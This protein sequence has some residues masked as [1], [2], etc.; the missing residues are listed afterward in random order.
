M[1]DSW[2]FTSLGRVAHV[3]MGQSPPSEYVSE[4]EGLGLPFLQGNAEFTDVHPKPGLWCRKPAKSALSG[5]ALISVRAPVGAINRADQDYCIGRGL[6][7]IRFSSV[8]PDFGYQA[9]ALYAAELRMVAQGTTFEAVGG[10]E[11]RE[12]RFPLAPALEQRRIAEILHTL[13]EA[14]RKTEEVIAKLQQMKQGLLHDLLTRGIDEN[15]ELRD[16]ERHPE[17]F[18]DSRL[19]RIPREWMTQRTSEVC[20]LGRGRVISQSYLLANPG[21]YPVYSSQSKDE[22][23]FG[24]IDTFDFEG[25]HVTWTTDGAYAGT[26][27]YRNGRFNCTNVCGTLQAK[28]EGLDMQYLALALAPATSRY[29][30]RVG[31]DKLMNNVMGE[32]CVPLPGFQEQSRIVRCLSSQHQRIAEEERT[33]SKLRTLKHG[34]MDDLLTGRVRVSVPEEAAA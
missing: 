27:F 9:L 30:S 6:A 17:Q 4:R 23:L 29:V 13:D 7:A 34:L 15:G 8:D 28:D 10:N 12:L 25:P 11:L 24:S 3:E 18:K 1:P 22:G 14:I 33:L 21:P 2:T 31:N 32:I 20:R 19:G 16:P 26:V 5:D